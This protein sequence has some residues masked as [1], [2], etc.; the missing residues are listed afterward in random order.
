MNDLKNILDEEDQPISEEML[1]RYLAGELHGDALHAVERQIA[2]S[3]FMNDAVE[4][5]HSMSPSRLDE[6]VK[7]LNQNLHD[8]LAEKRHRKEDRSVKG[9]PLILFAVVLILLLCILGYVV[10]NMHYNR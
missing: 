3:S 7:E 1:R 8:Q 5:L 10:L 6:Y 9:L 2:D 4:G